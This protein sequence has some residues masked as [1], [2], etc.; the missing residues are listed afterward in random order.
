MATYVAYEMWA[1]SADHRNL[2]S[3]YVVEARR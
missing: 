2:A 3:H 1:L